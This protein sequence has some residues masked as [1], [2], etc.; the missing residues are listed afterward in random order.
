[1]RLI[2]LLALCFFVEGSLYAG[3]DPFVDG[4]MADVRVR[5]VDD[6]GEPVEDALVSIVFM[7]DA[8]KVDVAKGLSDR[9]GYFAAARNCIGEMRLWVRK[10]GYYD[11]K[12][13]PTSFRE[14]SGVEAAKTHR[15]SKRTVVMPIILKKRRH[16]ARIPMHFADYKRYPA[17]NEV[18]K[19]DLEMLEWCPP[20]GR[21][22]HDDIHLIFEG[23]R[24][25]KEW[26]DF[27][28]NLKI[29]FP[30]GADGFYRVKVD[31]FSD[32]KYA[33]DAELKCTYEKELE[34]RHVRKTS[35]VLESKVLPKDE[36]L[37]FR[38]RT[39]TN[40]LGHVTHAHYGRIGENLSHYIGLSIKAWFNPKEDDVNLEGL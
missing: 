24:N 25:P 16:P 40:E 28:E 37:I 32:F 34:F 4:A 20:Y 35:G 36:Y 31:S 12:T 21:G 27:Y 13:H 33:Y 10:D 11:T 30:N 19:L 29:S 17:T 23:W 15:W 14:Y 2:L 6:R 9:D 18:F 3:Y 8:Q 7:T 5:V 38:V 1:M 22:K 26:L 39:Q